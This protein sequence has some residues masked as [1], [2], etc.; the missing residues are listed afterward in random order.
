VTKSILS[1]AAASGIALFAV[2]AV[3]SY[4]HWYDRV[5]YFDK[6]MHV[7]GGVFVFCALLAFLL[8]IGWM[9]LTMRAI[10]AAIVLTI[11]VG[12]LW[13]VYEYVIQQWTGAQLLTIPDSITDL[14][15]DT[16]GALIAAGVTF[17]VQ[18]AK[19]RYNTVNAN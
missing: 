7:F 17:F 2:N 6:W 5:Q 16:F 15:A 19:K 1:T 4:Y 9:Q 11:V 18:D 14:I 8:Q 13:E 10:L 12:F 3:A